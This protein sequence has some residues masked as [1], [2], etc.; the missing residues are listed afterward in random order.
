MLESIFQ[1]LMMAI[2]YYLF[3]REFFKFLSKI[4]SVKPSLM[5]QLIMFLIVYVWFL[6]ASY[7]ELPLII[8][9]F[10][11][12]IILGLEI[13]NVF[14][15][16]YLVSYAL[17]MFCIINGLAMNIFFRSLISIVSDIPLNVFDK[18]L[19]SV[20]AYPIF[21]GFIGMVLLLVCL[22]RFNFASRL[23]RLLENRKS[24]IFYT[25]TELFIYLFLIIQLLLYS[26]SDNSIGVK[27]WGIKS[28]IFSIIILVI[29]IIYSLRVASL[30]YYMDKKHEM[31][32]Q[33]LNDKE[34][35]DKFWDL[36]YTDILTG[37]GNRQLLD[38][39]LEEYSGYGGNITIAFID[40]NG[41]KKVNDMFG[42]AEGDKYLLKIV[43]VLLEITYEYNVDLFRYGGD[44][45]VM[46]SNSLN[47]H[48]LTELLN[49]RNT[50]LANDENK[51]YQKSI[52]FGVVRG[53]SINYSELIK[54]ADEK[55]Y[56]FK[57]QHYEDLARI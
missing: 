9:W 53:E 57:M 16:D 8:N 55:M 14:V 27:L 32:N 20:R 56:Q 35:I 48:T 21:L 51:I 18:T 2:T 29:T 40:I 5:K 17:S 50:I 28:S 36:A 49:E 52:S 15:F 54:Y 38:K 46:M 11:F 44:E 31:R 37:C 25:R 34:D 22:Q 6:F 3:S 30:Y 12:M 19:N 10:V 4:K 43:K 24:L 13:R 1:I 45:F 47:E 23:K 26:Q 7:L 41:L 42:H 33:L 39:R